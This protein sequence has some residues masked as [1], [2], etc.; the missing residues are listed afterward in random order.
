VTYDNLSRFKYLKRFCT[1]IDESFFDP[2]FAFELSCMG[3]NLFTGLEGCMTKDTTVELFDPYG[4]LAMGT[5]D[6][7]HLGRIHLSIG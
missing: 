7:Q 2:G 1:T 6:N 3:W 5:I 4:F